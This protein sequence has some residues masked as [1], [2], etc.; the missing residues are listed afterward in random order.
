MQKMWEKALETKLGVGNAMT[1][2]RYSWLLSGC[3]TYLVIVKLG[4][5]NP[6]PGWCKKNVRPCPWIGNCCKLHRNV[7]V[8]HDKSPHKKTAR[9]EFPGNDALSHK[10][11]G[12]TAAVI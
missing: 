4:K 2:K 11:L 10:P 8:C 5:T 1:V 7:F 3:V 9:H 6:S 12:I